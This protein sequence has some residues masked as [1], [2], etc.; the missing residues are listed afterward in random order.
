MSDLSP[1]SPFGPG[2]AA[3]RPLGHFGRAVLRCPAA[4]IATVGT[5]L[6]IVLP[7]AACRSACD[8][9]LAALWLGPDEWLL[10]AA[11]APDD[12]VATLQ[13]RLA[14]ALCSLVDV[15]HRQIALEIVDDRASADTLLASGCALDLS[16]AAFPVG[17]C[18]RT[19]YDK[20]EIVLWRRA[21]DRFHVEVWRSFARYVEG[22]LRVAESEA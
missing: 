16:L 1:A 15:S 18:T 19:M 14:D 10:L 11:D 8:E 9:T 6:G 22:L 4:M 21:P 20:A 5:R 17:M 12:W 3:I 7:V 2:S 13:A